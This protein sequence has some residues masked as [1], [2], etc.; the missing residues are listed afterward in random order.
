MHMRHV[1][2]KDYRNITR[3]KRYRLL[4]GFG[5]GSLLAMS[6]VL[7]YVCIMAFVNGGYVLLSVVDYNESVAEVVLMF[8]GLVL[9][10]VSII[11]VVKH[12]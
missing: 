5:L 11:L 9:G 1:V 6:W 10:T 7:F 3:T 8:I 4:I 12:T 2:E